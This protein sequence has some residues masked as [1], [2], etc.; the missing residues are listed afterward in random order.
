VF[1]ETLVY[2][3]R[4]FPIASRAVRKTLS[5]YGI[6]LIV[7]F[8]FRSF[9][10]DLDVGSPMRIIETFLRG[11]PIRAPPRSRIAA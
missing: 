3:V 11:Q 7:T 2:I 8:T 4:Q 9:S 5:I 6:T 10:T 1:R